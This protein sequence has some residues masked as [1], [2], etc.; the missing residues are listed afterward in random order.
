MEIVVVR[1]FCV[2]GE[3]KEVGEVLDLADPVAKEMLA[4]GKASLPVASHKDAAPVAET[5]KPKR[6]PKEQANEPL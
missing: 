2:A 6:K 5:T 1:A 4:L 3:R